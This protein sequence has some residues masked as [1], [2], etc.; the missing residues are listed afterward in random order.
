M[1]SRIVID[2]RIED[3]KP[4]IRDTYVLIQSVLADLRNG[5]SRQEFTCRYG[6]TDQDINAALA[7]T[8][9]CREIV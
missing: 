6:I 9:I 2:P 7:F 3:G 4:V 8:A 1:E 5:V